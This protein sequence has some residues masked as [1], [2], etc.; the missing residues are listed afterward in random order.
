MAVGIVAD[1]KLA[2]G[3]GLL[4]ARSDVDGLAADASRG[5]DP[6][7]EQHAAGVHPYADVEAIIAL[8]PLDEIALLPA[9]VEQRQAAAHRTLRIVLMGM[10][11]TEHGQ[12]AVACVFQ[13][14]AA[15]RCDDA[16]ELRQRAVHHGTRFLGVEALA[17]RRRSDDVEKQDGGLL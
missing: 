9:C 2:G 4:H 16:G 14:L 13:H 3:C 12:H 1:A 10:V 7:A 15:V 11:G 6:A 17:Q 5:I 8:P